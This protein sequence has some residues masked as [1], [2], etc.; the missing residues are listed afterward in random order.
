MTPP[1]NPAAPADPGGA[2]APAPEAV[3][4]HV[5]AGLRR[6]EAAF[7]DDAAKAVY[8]TNAG[9]DGAG[10]AAG[11]LAKLAPDG[12]VLAAE[13]VAGLSTPRGLRG[14]RGTL[15]VACGDHL[16]AVDV[17]KAA[18]ITRVPVPG[19]ERLTGVAV[20]GAGVVYA[21]DPP[22]GRVYAWDGSG[23]TVFAEG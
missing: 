8:V 14:A 22:A 21:S 1:P 13:W 18:V 9:P 20:D 6:P 2:P 3:A 12:R 11:F 16:A 4:W 10:D 19:A 17:A 7:Y 23:M 15:Y 5:A